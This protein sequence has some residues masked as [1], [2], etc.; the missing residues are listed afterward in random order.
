MFVIGYVS[1]VPCVYG[2][3]KGKP[4]SLH[5]ISP[6]VCSVRRNLDRV[7]DDDIAITWTNIGVDSGLRWGRCRMAVLALLGLSGT[8]GSVGV[9]RKC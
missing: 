8:V 4:S 9:W 2:S 5:L 7:R 3:L 6:N 1:A